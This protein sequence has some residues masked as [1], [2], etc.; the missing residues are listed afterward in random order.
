MNKDQI[1]YD[2]IDHILRK[3]AENALI[4]QNKSPNLVMESLCGIEN[5]PS[6]IQKLSNGAF[7][8][9]CYGAA[10]LRIPER[11]TNSTLFDAWR[12]SW[13]A[14]HN[15]P[16]WN[17]LTTLM[18]DLQSAHPGFNLASHYPQDYYQE[19]PA[20]KNTLNSFKRKD[21][22]DAINFFISAL[23]NTNKKEHKPSPRKP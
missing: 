2:M 4:A 13:T 6:V 21:N 18:K 15:G 1:S 16:R 3:W 11:F 7:I 9:T 5:T 20:L 19:L 12:R 17:A 22:A 14:D 23:P 10:I 8:Y